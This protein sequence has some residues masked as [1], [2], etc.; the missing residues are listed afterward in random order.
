MSYFS[1]YHS[2][3]GNSIT[4]NVRIENQNQLVVN[5]NALKFI[6]LP[7]NIKPLIS[8]A[9]MLKNK[10]LAAKPFKVN[11]AYFGYK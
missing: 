11:P 1:T 10:S 5:N 8:N 6:S 4:V 2:K 3:T 7:Q 9:K